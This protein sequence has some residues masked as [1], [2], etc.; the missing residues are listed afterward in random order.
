MLGFVPNSI[1]IDLLAEGVHVV[2][3]LVVPIV[4]GVAAEKLVSVVETP[5]DRDVFITGKFY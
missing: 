2:S 3:K 4:P 5:Q 1:I